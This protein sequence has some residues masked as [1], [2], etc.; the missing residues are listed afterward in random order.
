MT[1]ATLS[2]F[3]PTDLSAE[4]L[5]LLDVVREAV[6][7]QLFGPTRHAVNRFLAD[8]PVGVCV[9]LY[10]AWETARSAGQMTDAF[11][12]TLT[13]E[14]RFILDLVSTIYSVPDG[15]DHTQFP[16]YRELTKMAGVEMV[17]S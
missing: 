14:N 12:D 6:A 1:T 13:P 5:P 4:L 8:A 17:G 3:R 2:D 9:K 15:N 16:D 10:E 11:L 7:E